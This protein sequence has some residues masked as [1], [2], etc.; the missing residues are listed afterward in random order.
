M[1]FTPPSI[2]HIT[3]PR[4]PM[5]AQRGAAHTAW[6]LALAKPSAC[7]RHPPS[8]APA[9]PPPRAHRAAISMTAVLAPLAVCQGAAVSQELDCSSPSAALR[10]C[11]S[12]EEEVVACP[13]GAAEAAGPPSEGIVCPPTTARPTPAGQPS[14]LAAHPTPPAGAHHAQQ[15][16]SGVPGACDRLGAQDMPPEALPTEA[17][18][19]A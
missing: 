11:S 6:P 16:G 1:G 2:L 14:G 3:L 8:R 13:A 5:R 17:K 4:L 9:R 12:D 10:P 19:R 18:V 7:Q 15:P